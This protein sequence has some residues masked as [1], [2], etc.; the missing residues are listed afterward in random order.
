M[1]TPNEEE[2][3]PFADVDG[4]KLHYQESGT[5]ER[6]VVLLHAL[7]LHSGMWQPQIDTLRSRYRVIAPD[8]R[9][10]GQTGGVPAVTTMELLARDLIALLNQLGI[11]RAVFVGLS[12]GGYVAFEL[13]RR[14][15]EL[16][17]GLVL[18]DTRANA[19]TAEGAAGR[20]KTA[21]SALEK[22]LSWVADEMVP[23]LLRPL[24]DPAV[25]RTVRELVAGGTPGG[26]AALQRG[27][28]RRPDSIS[29]L[30]QIACPT[31]VV[32]GE[33]DALSP[34][35]VAEAM[36]AVIR[37]AQLARIPNA[38]HL[39]NLDNPSE[40]NRALLAFLDTLSF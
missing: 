23:K 20:E 29:T 38:G 37:G 14:A 16:F 6:T 21:L 7:P 36:A 13:Y 9:G 4:T 35:P 32:V 25:E 19:D 3:M 10:F 5:G 17:C 40:F 34:P 24:P 18:C 2:I 22:G 28:A 31:L 26:V 39:A 8:V 30:V 1:T 27:L 15:S 11:T 12:M 33:Q